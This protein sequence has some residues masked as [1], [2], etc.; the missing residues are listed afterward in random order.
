MVQMTYMKVLSKNKTYLNDTAIATTEM[1]N[2]N[3]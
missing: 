2:R 1:V 3:D